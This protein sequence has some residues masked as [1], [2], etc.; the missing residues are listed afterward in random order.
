MAMSGDGFECGKESKKVLM[1]VEVVLVVK[2]SRRR[3]KWLYLP[4]L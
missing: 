1:V 3:R 4:H 2:K